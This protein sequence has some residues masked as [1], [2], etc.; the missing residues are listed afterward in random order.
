MLEII[1]GGA[2][3]DDGNLQTLCKKHHAEKSLSE[4]ARRAAERKAH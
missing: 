1:D 3:F 4:K 2:P